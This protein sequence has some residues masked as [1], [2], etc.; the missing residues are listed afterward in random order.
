MICILE[1]IQ[2]A[3]L[4]K[5]MEHVQGGRKIYKRQ[6]GE[7]CRKKKVVGRKIILKCNRIECDDKECIHVAR[8]CDKKWA[9][10]DKITEPLGL[11]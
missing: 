1:L 7:N 3:S 4:G 2:E 6:V 5:D 10:V 8:D 11:N 9:V